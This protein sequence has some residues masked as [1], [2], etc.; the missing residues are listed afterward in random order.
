MG[1][2]GKKEIKGPVTQETIFKVMMTMTVAVGA[3][4]FLKN[5]MG[6]LQRVLS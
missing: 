1:N 5:I 2:R 4:F 3:V 6:A